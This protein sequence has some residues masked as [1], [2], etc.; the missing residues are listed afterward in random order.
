MV[1]YLPRPSETDLSP[2]RGP[3]GPGREWD[4]EAADDGA[5]EEGA[6]EDGVA[7]A[8]GVEEGAAEEAGPSEAL[9]AE[10]TTLVIAI[11]SIT[12]TS[13]SSAW[14]SCGASASSGTDDIGA[15]DLRRAFAGC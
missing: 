10:E 3:T 13:A 9:E 4:G 15:L 2:A 7:E 14:F 5:A 1:R 8:G 12:S 11:P 6:A